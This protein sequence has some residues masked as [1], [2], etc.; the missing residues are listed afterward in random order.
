MLA[1]SSQGLQSFPNSAPEDEFGSLLLQYQAVRH[2]T[3]ELCEPLEADD[4]L[5]QS[6]ADASPVKWHLAHTTWFFETFL[7][8]KFLPG[9]R[10]YHPQFNFLF[11]SYYHAAGPRWP[12]SQRG[13]LSRP[14]VVDVSRYRAHVDEHMSQLLQTA[15]GQAHAELGAVVLLGVNHE[16]Q[17]Q[18]LILTDLK[19]AWAANP[20]CPV[21]REASAEAGTPSSQSWL[22]FAEGVGWIGRNGM[23]FAF[24]NESPRHRVF[25]QG[26]QL[27]NRLATNGEYLAFMADAGYER[28]ELWL[29]DGWA[30]RQARDWLAPLYWEKR[31]GVWTQFT[32]A[33]QRLLDPAEPL[34]HVSFYEAD[35][36]ARWA[37]ARLPTE[38]E[39]EC[40]A[41]SAPTAGHFLESGHFHPSA[42]PANDGWDGLAGSPPLPQGAL[43]Q[44]FGDVWQWTAS[45]Y[46]AYPGY[47]PPAGALGEYNGKF[48]C[49]QMV[50]RGAS[51][52]TPRSHARLTY[53]N[54]F[55]PDAR[56]QF[57]GVRLARDLV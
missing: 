47:A 26:F 17:H 40:A 32:L 48:M 21:Y 20:L 43:V 31:D 35:A 16:Q 1:S 30:V 27:A 51:C 54:F 2:K 34:V 37:G 45:P 5:I 46:V 56:W 13:L 55:P 25:L 11:N 24:D 49:N 3:E 12:R 52:A 36:F 14:T 22:P 50:L 4:Y 44:L 29:S 7:L 38:A 33:G 18:E 39:W 6:M 28:P 10:P 23:G 19:H 9:Y 15:R 57:S 42:R 8:A 53:R 41:A